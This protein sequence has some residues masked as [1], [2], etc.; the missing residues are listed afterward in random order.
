MPTLYLDN[1]LKLDRCPH[2]GIAHPMLSAIHTFATRDSEEEN[3]R[4]WRVYS[5]SRCGGVVTAWAGRAG[6]SVQEYFPH[7]FQV[8]DDIPP[9]AAEYLRQALHSLSAPAGAVM[10]AASSVDAMLKAKGFPDGTL[11]KRIDAAADAHVITTEMAAWAHEVRL[12]ANDQR[13]AD[14]AA[15]LPTTKDA[16]RAIRFVIALGEFMFV[17]P[18]KVARGRASLQTKPSK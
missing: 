2:C 8:E 10:L 16:E 9:K 14:A 11:Y 6:A 15:E 12:D 7:S 13:H 3:A 1:A 18:A 5:C 4:A 17:L